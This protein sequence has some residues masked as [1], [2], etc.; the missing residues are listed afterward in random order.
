MDN[1]KATSPSPEIMMFLCPSAH[2]TVANLPGCGQKR[3][4]DERLQQ[5]IVLMVDKESRSTSKQ[6]QADLQTQGTTVSARTIRR[7]LNEMGRYGRRPRRTPLLTQRHRK[8]R[9]E[10]AKTYLRKPKS[11]WENIMW[12]DETKV[13]LFTK[14][15]YC[16]VYRKLNEA[17]K[18]KGLLCCFWHRMS[19]LCAWHHEI[20]RLLKNF[21]A[22]CRAQCQKAGSP[23]EVM[24]LP[25]GQWPKAYFKKHT[26]I[27]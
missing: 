19:W 2:G 21:G 22:Q 25:A 4:I 6:I 9:L 20:W 26:E 18:E 10:F 1:L 7:H 27:V 23:S 8:A 12:T 17:F 24:G 16:T 13:E 5:R 15:Y 14:A 11:F 3:K